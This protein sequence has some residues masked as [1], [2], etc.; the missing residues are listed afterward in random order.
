M[1]ATLQNWG[2]GFSATNW[3]NG[4]VLL[5]LIGQSFACGARRVATLQWGEG[6]LGVNPARTTKDHH[7]VMHYLGGGAGETDYDMDGDIDVEDAQQL[8][9]RWYADRFESCLS[10]FKA[11]GIFGFAE[12]LIFLVILIAGYV[13]VWKKGALEWV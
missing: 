5:D 9:D 4:D 11:L 1:S 2:T 3:T 6:A 12:I 13:W 8:C 10:K 7:W